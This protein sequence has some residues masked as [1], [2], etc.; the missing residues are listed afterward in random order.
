MKQ[1]SRALILLSAV[2]AVAQQPARPYT[3]GPV[4]DVQFIKQRTTEARKARKEPLV[5]RGS[6]LP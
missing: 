4:T 2:P 1:A 5:I 6:Q 3:E